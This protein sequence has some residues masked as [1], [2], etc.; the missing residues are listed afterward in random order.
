MN[1]NLDTLWNATVYSKQK[2][3]EARDYQWASEMGGPLVDRYLKMKGIEPSNPPNMRSLRKFDAGSLTEWVVRIVL[4]RAGIIKDTQERVI[5]EYPDLLKV[6]GKL[7]FLIGGKIDLERAKAEI[8]ILGLPESIKQASL[9]IAE[10][11]YSMYGGVELPTKVIEVKS[12]S[13][14]VMDRME[15][16]EMPIKRHVYQVFHYMKGLNLPG[17][18]AYICRDDLRMKCFSFEPTAE[19]ERMYV[20]DLMAITKFYN[21]DVRPDLEPLII[22]ENGRFSKNLDVEYSGY[23]TMLYGFET[24]RDYSD[25][26]KSKVARWTRVVARYANGDNITKKNAEVR[27]EI[28]REGYDFDR[29][30]KDAQRF[31]VTVEEEND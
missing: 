4:S 30:V 11:L 2:P 18:I 13:S 29:I 28:L 5:V 19:L 17:E 21:D 7:D 24:P 9:Y 14:F 25:S 31:G 1:Y 15:K 10:N 20:S 26:V 8:E 23:L 16:D 6:S 3:A 22:L 12:C 27:D